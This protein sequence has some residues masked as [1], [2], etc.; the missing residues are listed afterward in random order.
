MYIGNCTPQFRGFG[1][2]K[3]GNCDKNPDGIYRIRKGIMDF[4]EE[5]LKHFSDV[6][7]MFRISGRDA[8]AP[9]LAVAGND[10][11]Y[12]K[13]IGKRFHLDINVS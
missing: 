10:E 8:Y 1:K 6:P 9:M 4:V 5:Y 2:E 11:K 13:E 3:F 12:L 7:Y